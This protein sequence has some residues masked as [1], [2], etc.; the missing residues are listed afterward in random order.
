[1]VTQ[2]NCADKQKCA[3]IN[4]QN[5]TMTSPADERQKLQIQLK[6]KQSALKQTMANC[7]AK[8]QELTKA[9]NTHK[10]TA[11]STAKHCEKTLMDLISSLQKRGDNLTNMIR[12]HEKEEERNVVK[13]LTKL[14][15][16]ISDMKKKHDDLEKLSQVEDD[17]YVI[18]HPNP[19][20]EKNAS[21]LNLD[22][23]T[24]SGYLTVTAKSAVTKRDLYWSQNLVRPVLC[25]EKLSGCSYFEIEYGPKGCSVVFSFDHISVFHNFVANRRSWRFDFP[26]ADLG[27][28]HMNEKTNI[29]LISKIGVFLNQ[30]A[31]TLSFF[32]VSDK[33]VLLH[34][35]EI[36]S[37]DPLTLG[38]LFEKWEP[39]SSVTI[40]DLSSK[41]LV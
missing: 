38:F 19:R 14:N 8:V 15:Q 11:E 25:K 32:N 24:T 31:R 7:E 4:H 22:E 28:F 16:E 34:R 12:S 40:C 33:M 17:I 10:S 6:S 2:F 5:H 18:Q 35:L 3:L 27:L 36:P 23:S 41:P 1:M 9:L 39:N 13:F 29:S 30:P 37:S 21:D 20:P 26:N